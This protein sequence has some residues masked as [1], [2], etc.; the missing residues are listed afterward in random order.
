MKVEVGIYNNNNNK[1]D[2]ITFGNNIMLS[3]I[4][5]FTLTTIQNVNERCTV[6]FFKL[7]FIFH[8]KD[9]HT[10]NLR[11]QLHRS[12]RFDVA[13]NFIYSS[14]LYDYYSS[15]ILVT[16]TIHLFIYIF[17][18]QHFWAVKFYMEHENNTS[19][20]EIPKFQKLGKKLKRSDKL[21]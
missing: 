18:A 5:F 6:L 14:C 13:G 20:L 7:T 4:Y 11:F 19:F 10:Y 8:L 17:Q 16:V 9:H 21:L 12:N 2:K 3:F 1:H 15:F